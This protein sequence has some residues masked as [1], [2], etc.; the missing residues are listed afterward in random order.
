[1]ECRRCKFF[2]S[3]KLRCED[4]HEWV[5]LDGEPVCRYQPAAILIDV[6]VKNLKKERD[7]YKKL[8][9]D[10]LKAIKNFK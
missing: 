7:H 8:Y 2:N 1:M 6:A 3:D 9:E 10:R 5:N 4:S